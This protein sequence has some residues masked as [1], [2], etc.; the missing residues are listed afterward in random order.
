MLFHLNLSIQQAVAAD[1][2]PGDAIP[3]SGLYQSDE[4]FVS[5]R[6]ND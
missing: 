6:I 5:I 4:S 1:V 2:D 3:S